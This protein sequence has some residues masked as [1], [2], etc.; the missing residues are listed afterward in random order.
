VKK[1]TRIAIVG[2]GPAGLSAAYH[3]TEIDED[4]DLDIT[5][6][7]LGWRLGGKAS[8]GRD[9]GRGNRIEEHGIHGFCKFYFNTWEMMAKVYAQVG[10]HGPNEEACLPVG[11]MRDA[12]LPSST[13]YNVENVD[14]FWTREVGAMPEGEGDPWTGEPDIRKSAIL[15]GLLEKMLQRDRVGDPGLLDYSD[16]V[17]QPVGLEMQQA[18]EM[19]QQTSFDAY[20]MARDGL[21]EVLDDDSER[22]RRVLND[23]VERLEAVREP[24]AAL[25]TQMDLPTTHAQVHRGLTSFDL[26]LALVVGLFRMRFWSRDFDLDDADPLDYRD[27]LSNCRAKD[28]TL[29]SAAVM[30]VANILFAYPDGD[31]T[32]APELSA[33]SWLNWVLRSLIGNGA[34]FHFFAAGSGETVMLPLYKALVARGVNFEF[35]HKLTGVK[36]IGKKGQRTLEELTFERQATVTSLDY[37][38]LM[39]MNHTDAKGAWCVW[40]NHPNWEQLHHGDVNKNANVD[41]EDW[42]LEDRPGSS[43][44]TLTHGAEEDGFDYA[45]WALPPSMIPLVGDEKMRAEWKTTIDRLPTT[46]TQAVQVWLTR[47][48]KDLGWPRNN[49]PRHTSR[50]ASGGFPN[51]LSGMAAL[52]DVIRFEDWGED[53]PKGLI[54]FC[55][56][57]HDWPGGQSRD[58]DRIRVLQSAGAT[59]RLLGSF[60]EGARPKEPDRPDPQAIDFEYLYDPDPNHEGEQRLSCQYARPNTR[61]TEA[62]VRAPAGSVAGRRDAWD[63]G[64]TNLTVAGDWMYNGFNLGSFESAVTGGKLAAFALAGG[65][66]P[67]DPRGL[68]FL[69]PGARKRAEHALAQGIVPMIK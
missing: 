16:L 61:P 11:T 60:L 2:G 18:A 9:E 17:A 54:Y 33:A 68:T 55:G 49:L 14:R 12:F 20:Q 29:A 1:P 39:K 58:E 64:F 8:T 53:G 6:Y 69:H 10:E 5:I 51:P 30:T 3:L 63:S 52:D 34:Y 13:V 56:Q 32:R 7:Q 19:L 36:T 43:D 15:I 37:D 41:Y 42:N 35:F 21:M 44:R 31:S 4:R 22:I 45:V 40:P 47:D 28:H 24:L 50:Y 66:S 65:A 46:A 23:V 26:G 57:L 27:W 48:T 38:P 67:V 25:W 59:L 62:Y